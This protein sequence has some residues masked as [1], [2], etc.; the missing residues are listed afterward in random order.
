MYEIVDAKTVRFALSRGQ[1]ALINT[2][3]FREVIKHA[4]SCRIS[5]AN[6]T[7]LYAEANIKV[8]G[9]WRRVALHRFLMKPPDGTFVDHINGNGLDCRRDNMRTTKQSG[10]QWNTRSHR[11]SIS[12]FKGVS[13]HSKTKRW[14]AQITAFRKHHHLGCYATEE[15]AARAYDVAAKRL[16][17][18]FAYLNF[19]GE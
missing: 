5:G 10:N 16:H 6:H 17:G 18:E 8:D 4:W 2:S 19:P 1:W 9:W 3:D 13:Q 7:Q 11:D 15:E 14:V 12:T